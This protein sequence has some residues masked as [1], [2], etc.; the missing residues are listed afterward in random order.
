MHD[1][2]EFVLNFV[3]ENLA[4]GVRKQAE[5]VCS[6]LPRST[7]VCEQMTFRLENWV[8]V[9]HAKRAVRPLCAHQAYVTCAL[10]PLSVPARAVAGASPRGGHTD[11]CDSRESP[12]RDP[13]EKTSRKDDSLGQKFS[14]H[15]CIILHKRDGDVFRRSSLR[16]IGLRSVSASSRRLSSPLLLSISQQQQ[17]TRMK[18]CLSR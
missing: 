15:V 10:D 17:R 4:Q 13:R 16:A 8:R 9:P 6:M 3:A 7:V 11:V 12:R 18:N 14:D 5:T 1:H 2:H